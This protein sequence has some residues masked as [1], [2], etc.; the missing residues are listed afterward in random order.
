LKARSRTSCGEAKAAMGSARGLQ[1][2]STIT[3]E[4]WE[5][6]GGNGISEVVCSLKAR[7][8][9]RCGKAKVA[10]GSARG[11]AV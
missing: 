9:T 10:T 8:H 1:F 4:L 11:S 5:G 3:Y 7:S 2:E 6:E